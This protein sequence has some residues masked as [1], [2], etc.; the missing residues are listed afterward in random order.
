MLDK[1]IKLSLNYQSKIGYDTSFQNVI[2]KKIINIM[3]I[4]LVDI[5][6]ETKMKYSRIKCLESSLLWLFFLYYKWK[7]IWQKM[8]FHIF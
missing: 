5:D 7:L 1:Y 4:T 3:G 6:I 8:K 2:L